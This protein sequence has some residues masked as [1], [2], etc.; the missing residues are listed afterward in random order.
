ME[1]KGYTIW[2]W[3]SGPDMK[4]YELFADESWYFHS[5]TGFV[6]S[7]VKPLWRRL[8]QDIGK[9]DLDNERTLLVRCSYCRYVAL[10]F[11][12]LIYV[13][14]RSF[15]LK[16]HE[17]I[18]LLMFSVLKKYQYKSLWGR[19]NM[20]KGKYL[21]NKEKLWKPLKFFFS[22]SGFLFII[23]WLVI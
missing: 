22:L 6:I 13:L 1:V 3:P 19:R 11:I 15:T 10:C 4:L 18:K 9:V 8:W 17:S 20:K 21:N 5:D 14:G 2:G 16:W 12:K 7:N 23:K